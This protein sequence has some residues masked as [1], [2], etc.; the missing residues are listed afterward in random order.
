MLL[1]DIMASINEINKELLFVLNKV[2]KDYELILER[3]EKKVTSLGYLLKKAK[4]NT[5][6]LLL[7]RSYNLLKH[8]DYLYLS[9]IPTKKLATNKWFFS[10]DHLTGIEIYKKVYNLTST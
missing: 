7:L 8:N 9:L 3:C 6:Q 2:K 5:E 1:L 10:L 4:S